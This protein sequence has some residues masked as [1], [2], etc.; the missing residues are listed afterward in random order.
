MRSKKKIVRK[1]RVPLPVLKLHS[2]AEIHAAKEAFDE[3]AA[4]LKKALQTGTAAERR[5]AHAAFR[6]AFDAYEKMW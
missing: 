2:V 1:R 4:A 3:T 6:V 5:T